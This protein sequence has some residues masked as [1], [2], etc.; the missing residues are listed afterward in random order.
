MAGLAPGNVPS[1][2][3]KANR[4]RR[5]FEPRWSFPHVAKAGIDEP[6]AIQQMQRN[7]ACRGSE[8]ECMRI[9]YAYPRW[10]G[11]LPAWKDHFSHAQRL[12]FSHVCL[13]PIFAPAANGDIFLADDF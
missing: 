10:I 1:G 8:Q 13:G 11:A 5:N 4:W 7:S 6:V 2:P 9:Y 12:G 3:H